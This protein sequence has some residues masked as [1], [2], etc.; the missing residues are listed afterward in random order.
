[1]QRKLTPESV[2]ATIGQWQSE[3]EQHAASPD[4]EEMVVSFNAHA[5]ALR[6]QYQAQERLRDS[7][8]SLLWVL[9][10]IYNAIEKHI[11]AVPAA[12][13]D[14]QISIQNVIKEATAS[15]DPVD[16]FSILVV[17]DDIKKQI[18]DS[19]EVLNW[20]Y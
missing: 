16:G 4:Y 7:A 10:I 15:E 3:L 2:E 14:L 17:P 20:P 9:H 6:M 11:E 1:M 19:I 13:A 12:V 8:G 5:A 18:E